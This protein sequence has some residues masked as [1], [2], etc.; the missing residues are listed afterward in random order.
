[1]S[2]LTAISP[3][4]NVSVERN[5]ISLFAIHGVEIVS[6][7]IARGAEKSFPR[8]FKK[9]CGGDLPAPARWSDIK[10]GKALWTG[11]D[12]YFLF[13]DGVDDHAD[14]KLAAQFNGKAYTTLQSDGWSGL[15][16]SGPRIYDLMERFIAL[17]L[18]SAENDFGA[19]TSAHHMAVLVLKTAKDRFELFTPR[20]SSVSFLEAL[21]HEI[22]LV[23][24]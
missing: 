13:L 10:D 22:E 17:D 4:D 1:M 11:P 8:A 23:D 12:Q 14:E 21:K 20:S 19:R 24:S 7:A 18:R 15:S 2:K 3:F 9:V 5:D 16:V 6:L